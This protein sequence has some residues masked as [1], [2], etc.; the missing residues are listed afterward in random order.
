MCGGDAPQADPCMLAP[1]RAPF[2]APKSVHAYLRK[3]TQIVC[4]AAE[5]WALSDVARVRSRARRMPRLSGYGESHVASKEPRRRSVLI[6][7]ARQQTTFRL[8]GK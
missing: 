6:L 1:K 8:L 2:G 4:Q 3:S 5:A 7:T